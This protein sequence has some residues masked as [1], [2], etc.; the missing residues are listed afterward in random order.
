[1]GSP[2]IRQ[3]ATAPP[4]EPIVE[5]T[6]CR[7]SD[8]TGTMH[9]D[10]PGVLQTTFTPGE[11]ARITL[12]A[13]SSGQSISAMCVLRVASAEDHAALIPDRHEPSTAPSGTVEDVSGGHPDV[14]RD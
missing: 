2:A 4:D 6:L 13:T 8:T 12:V 7:V 3:Q 11:T 5:V 10:D 9:T 14:R 1:M